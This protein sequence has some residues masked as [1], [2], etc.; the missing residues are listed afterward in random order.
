MTKGNHR[1][2]R[3]WKVRPFS[4]EGEG[5]TTTPNLKPKKAEPQPAPKP[6]PTRTPRNGP[7]PNMKP[8]GSK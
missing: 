1:G 7:I 4:D 3:K 2:R 5:G 6:K 8:P